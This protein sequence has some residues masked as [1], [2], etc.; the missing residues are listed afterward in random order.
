MWEG[1]QSRSLHFPSSHK[2][3]RY[4][5]TK[6]RQTKDP[7]RSEPICSQVAQAQERGGGGGG[8]GGGYTASDAKLDW[9]VLQQRFYLVN[10]TILA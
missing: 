2:F 5:Q 4:Y 3:F 1:V 6:G 8:G 7:H 10:I 9:P